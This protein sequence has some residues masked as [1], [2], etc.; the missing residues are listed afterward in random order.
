[1]AEATALRTIVADGWELT[2]AGMRRER[3]GDVH[4]DLLLANGVPVYA[5]RVALFSP[6]ERAAFAQA[7]TGPGRPDAD[8][9]AS[10]LL[11]LA[12]DILAGM[13]ESDAPRRTQADQL[14][15]LAHDAGVVLF[16]TP[17]GDPY[18]DI[19]SGDHR[20]TWPLRA[21]HVRQWLAR[22][23]YALHAKA[24]GSQAMQDALGVL[25]GRALYDG[26]TQPVFVRVAGAGGA[27]YLD[28]ADDQWRAVEIRADGWEIVPS[29]PV[30]FRR[31]K[32]M[33]A[34]PDPAAGG[35]LDELRPFLNLPDDDAWALTLAWLLQALRP[36][37]P[38]PV[39]TLNGEQGSAKSTTARVVRALVDPSTV[40]LRRPPRDDRDLMIAASNAWTVV[41]DNLSGLPAW[42]SDT[43]CVLSTGGG[44]ATRELYA[45]ADETLFD[46]Q[47]PVILTG[48][49][50]VVTRGDLLDRSLALTLP[51]IPDERRRTEATFWRD[52]DAA[53]PRILGALLTRVATALATVDTLQLDARPRMADFAQWVAAGEDAAG[54]ARFLD[55]YATN[56]ASAHD[57]ALDGSLLAGA[58]QAFMNGRQGWQG[59]AGDLL[60]ELRDHVTDKGRDS[61][62]W[63]KTPRALSGQ[64]RRLAPHLRATGLA[65]DFGE[66]AGRSRARL[67]TIAR[68][69]AGDVQSEQGRT[70]PSAP[71]APSAPGEN[72]QPH[73]KTAPERADGEM[74]AYSHQAAPTPAGRAY[75]TCPRCGEPH[76]D[77][78]P[79]GNARCLSCAHYVARDARQE[80]G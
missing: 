35:S 69:A 45:N 22:Q 60:A 53:R 63:P 78:Y 59:T 37:G 21:K 80:G 67:L 50:D 27:V 79:S 72:P 40:P 52:F 54:R 68:R 57:S 14:V 66:R 20:E 5:A 6:A 13:Q 65:L 7:A 1:V 44:Y 38:Y 49:E 8:A 58:L 15:A 62:A 33:L 28:L 70:Q 56:R 17:E 36:T 71:S 39:L 74:Q 48:I 29:A 2:A 31:A 41:L 55:A 23:F 3:G 43:L 12:P 64:L 32:G 30:R 4:A 9:I 24:P 61:R 26:E 18:A 47:R 10:A 75:E 42:L 25:E 46:A 73:A 76:L 77:R 34:L 16:R 51:A 19:P 11:A